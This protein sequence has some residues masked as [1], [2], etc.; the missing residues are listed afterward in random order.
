MDN[1]CSNEEINVYLKNRQESEIIQKID[2]L[3]EEIESKFDCFSIIYL[4]YWRGKII[5][6]I[7]YQKVKDIL[8]KFTQKE[9][10]EYNEMAKMFTDS[11]CCFSFYNVARIVHTEIINILYPKEVLQ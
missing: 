6:E 9:L 8:N 1:K 10:L 11:N 2:K 7:M 3:M 5:K 4:D